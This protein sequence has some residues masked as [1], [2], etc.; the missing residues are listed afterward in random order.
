[1]GDHVLVTLG[2][3]LPAGVTCC[4][5]PALLLFRTARAWDPDQGWLPLEDKLFDGS[6]DH[7]KESISKPAK[8]QRRSSQ[9][10]ARGPREKARATPQLSRSSSRSLRQGESDIVR[11]RTLQSSV[12]DKP[13]GVQALALPGGPR[14][15]ASDFKQQPDGGNQ[16]ASGNDRGLPSKYSTSNV[17]L[18]ASDVVKP[19]SKDWQGDPGE[20]LRAGGRAPSRTAY[21]GLTDSEDENSS[22]DEKEVPRGPARSEGQG[23][24]VPSG[25]SGPLEGK[26]PFGDDVGRTRD[27]DSAEPPTPPPFLNQGGFPDFEGNRPLSPKLTSIQAKEKVRATGLKMKVD[28]SL[29]RG[30]GKVKGGQDFGEAKP[31]PKQKE[32]GG[33]QVKE[34]NRRPTAASKPSFSTKPS[35]TTLKDGA[36][37]PLQA[38]K[39]AKLRAQERVALRK[40]PTGAPGTSL[41]PKDLAPSLDKKPSATLARPS[42]ANRPVTPASGSGAGPSGGLGGVVQASPDFDLA[43]ILPL[44]GLEGCGWTQDD[45]NKV[46]E[47]VQMF[48]RNLKCLEVQPSPY[49]MLPQRHRGME[50]FIVFLGDLSAQ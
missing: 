2:R 12:L 23:G 10:N 17:R 27:P 29:S 15:Q 5:Q 41:E 49:A 21:L 9:P 40:G 20:K 43:G 30:Q 50:W 4:S 33:R 48:G 37:L 11:Q 7:R 28:A 22:S 8:A 47:V 1:M 19:G 39:V 35:A 14:A 25:I 24:V 34:P 42:S 45:S 3:L 46:L 38:A 36:V 13:K 16:G 31:G 44:T 18:K 32:A 6:E 26:V